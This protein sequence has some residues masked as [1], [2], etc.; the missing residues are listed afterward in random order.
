MPIYDLFLKYVLFLYNTPQM[1]FLTKTE[2]KKKKKSRRS[3][4]GMKAPVW[5]FM[6]KFLSKS[7][8]CN[9]WNKK[10]TNDL[11]A[12]AQPIFLLCC[13]FQIINLKNV[14]VAETQTLLYL[15]YKTIFLSKSRVCN[16]SNKKC[17]QCS[18]TFLCMPSLYSYFAAISNFKSF[19]WKL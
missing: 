17:D 1:T 14:E 6:V 9:S 16:S 11:Y 4:K 13:R 2:Q 18:V 8:V 5:L 12:H 15:M 19:S 10:L 3:R 7:K